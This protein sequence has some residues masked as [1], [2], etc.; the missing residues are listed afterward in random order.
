MEGGTGKGEPFCP[1][2]DCWLPHHVRG[3]VPQPVREERPGKYPTNDDAKNDDIDDDNVSDDNNN[4]KNDDDDDDTIDGTIDGTVYDDDDDIVYDEYDLM[5][6]SVQGGHRHVPPGWDWWFG[7]VG[8]SKY[9]NYTLSINGKA[10]HHG[11]NYTQVG[12]RSQLSSNILQILE[13]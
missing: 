13:H 5:D 10:K 12:H 9:Y 7:L 3:E 2:E 4:N 11:D 6:I 1:T 8:N